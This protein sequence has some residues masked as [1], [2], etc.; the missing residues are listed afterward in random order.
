MPISHCAQTSNQNSLTKVPTGITGLDEVTYGGLPR[1]RN[2]LI[3]GSAGSGK[4]ILSLAFLANGARLYKEPGFFVTF[5]ES[6]E[7]LISNSRSMSFGLEELVDNGRIKI[8]EILL[9]DIP[10][11]ELA[12]Y[13]LEGLAARLEHAI[14][15]VGAK[16]IVLD[17]LEAL[18]SRFKDDNTIRCEVARLFR[19]LHRKE[20]T[21]IITAEQGTGNITRR[22]MEEYLADCVISLSQNIREKI[23]TRQL[24]IV[25]YRGSEH[26]TN[27]YPF[28]IN[29]NGPHVLPITSLFLSHP[30]PEEQISSGIRK[31][32]EMLGGQGLY[33]G[34]AVL[35]TGTSGTGKTSMAST[36]A[37]ATCSRNGRCLYCSF[38]ES[39]AQV[40]RNMKSL[41][42][43]LTPYIKS[44]LLHFHGI[45]PT[46]AGLE[47]H[48]ADII[49]MVNEY[50]PDMVVLDPVSNLTLVGSEFEVR[51]MLMRLLDFLKSK[52]ITVVSTDLS[53]TEE[54]SE[55]TRVG[56]S[57]LMDTWFLLRNVELNG[58]RNR[59][60]FII[61]SRGQKHSNQVREFI[62]TSHGIEL[63]E[64]YA[65]EGQVIT[66]TARLAKEA[67]DKSQA[68]AREAE[69]ANIKN[70]LESER[71]LLQYRL[72]TI[73]AK[74]QATESEMERFQLS[75]EA[76][77]E[78]RSLSDREQRLARTG[79]D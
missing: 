21:T 11:V 39:E 47:L 79:R 12:G 4:T 35:I 53:P 65:S 57:S 28:F 24:R 33:R 69:V 32:D 18:V 41:G 25:K 62:L 43:D 27:E 56:I 45:R 30:A 26:G 37:H 60:L 63:V 22:N 49:E 64:I 77:N 6:Q 58:E 29:G 52:M 44:G 19:W 13:D 54:N 16:R 36:M 66:G 9:E 67:R 23:L 72:N 17:S 61:K 50:A 73:Q 75:V 68:E 31:L 3:A 40:V 20:I 76:E 5:D 74:I 59:C 55:A 15:S 14:D 34:S 48:L 42:L 70:K 38:E 78:A 2:T 46:L 8:D 71:L 51:I 7:S 1:G 10:T